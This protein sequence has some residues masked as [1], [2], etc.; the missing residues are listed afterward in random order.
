MSLERE[1]ALINSYKESREKVIYFVLAA[2]GSAI[3]FAMTQSK[4]EAFAIHHYIWIVAISL[5]A[6]SFFCG[7]QALEYLKQL[8]LNNAMVLRSERKPFEDVGIASGPLPPKVALSIVYDQTNKKYNI[9]SRLQL[10]CLLSGAVI[11]I[12]WHIVK[13]LLIVTT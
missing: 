6:V 1:D 11:Y 5:W 12:I 10:Y 9:Y 13:M 4:T 3:G 8:T 7:I 2:S